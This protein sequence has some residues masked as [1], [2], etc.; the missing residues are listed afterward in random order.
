MNP[1]KIYYHLT[2]QNYWEEF[3]TKK[4]DL[5]KST[6]LWDAASEVIFCLHY[7]TA[8]IDKIHEAVSDHKVRIVYNPESIRPYGE[9]YTNLTIKQEA[10]DGD[11]DYYIFRFHNKGINHYNT[12]NWADNK[13]IADE[14]NY[15]NI[16]RWQECVDKLDQGYQAVGTN[17]VKQPWPHFKGNYWWVTADYMRTMTPLQPPHISG[18]IQQIKGGGWTIH[19][20]ESWIGTGTPRAYDILRGTDQIGDHPDLQR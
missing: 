14:M 17:W 6:G 19:D 10:D 1:I 4:I 3:Y 8:S 20:A 18:G 13:A 16:N 5:M 11:D 7:D 2:P 15:H 9:Q 12:V